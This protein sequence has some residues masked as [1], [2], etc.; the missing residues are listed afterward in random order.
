MS[1]GCPPEPELIPVGELSNDDCPVGP[2]GTIG[3]GG[4]TGGRPVVPV[5]P[6]PKPVPVGNPPGGVI[7]VGMGMW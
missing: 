6:G 7:P 1:E 4:I 2:T 5:G 3:Y